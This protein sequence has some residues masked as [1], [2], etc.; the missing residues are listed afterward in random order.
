MIPCIPDQVNF[1]LTVFIILIV[2]VKDCTVIFQ[3]FS[4]NILTVNRFYRFIKSR[5]YEDNRADLKEILKL[6]HL[7]SNNPY[8]F[9]QISHGV[10]Y[11]DDFWI[12]F[13]NEKLSWK[14]VKIR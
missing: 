9:I 5:C 11:S 4:G 10:T 8:D 6:S 14:D 3:P 1:F 13:E 2:A 12:R 7:T